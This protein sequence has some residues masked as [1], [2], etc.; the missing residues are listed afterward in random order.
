MGGSHR[1]GEG[2]GQVEELVALEAVLW[3]EPVK[4]LARDVLHRQETDAF[5]F[6]D[7][8]N[9]D[10]VGVGESRDRFG[11][12]LKAF[13]ATGMRG[14]L[15]RQDFERDL[16]LEPNV[17]GQVDLPHPAGAQP[18]GDPVVG[19]HPTD[20]E[21]SSTRVSGIGTAWHVYFTLTF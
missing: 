10:D 19:E 2:Q 11:L 7:R 15:G 14:E 16:A 6:L 13:G 17:L 3:D 12:T 1:A 5:S 20:H 21:H 4:R 18:V 9:R 8:V